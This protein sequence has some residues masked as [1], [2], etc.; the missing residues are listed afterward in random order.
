MH[1][2]FAYDFD[3]TNHWRGS[4]FAPYARVQPH[5]SVQESIMD[6]R[7]QFALPICV[8][9]LRCQPVVGEIELRLLALVEPHRTGK[10][11]FNTLFF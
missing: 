10:N 2:H 8:A 11:C 9:N 6:L 3:L 7:C 4:Y 1:K 5:A